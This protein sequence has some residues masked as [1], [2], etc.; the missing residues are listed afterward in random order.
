MSEPFF[1]YFNVSD[2][3]KASKNPSSM[4]ISIKCC[5]RSDLKHIFIEIF[6]SRRWQDRFSIWLTLLSQ[7]IFTYIQYIFILCNFILFR[8]YILLW[9]GRYIIS[10]NQRNN[11]NNRTSRFTIYLIY[12]Y[13]RWIYTKLCLLIDPCG[14]RHPGNVIRWD[15]IVESGESG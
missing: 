4:K 11:H 1:L 5:F 15:V 13:L 12:F 3:I 8:G 14:P 9:W 7:L 6:L 10:G 2:H